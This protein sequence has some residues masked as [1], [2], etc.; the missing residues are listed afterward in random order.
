MRCLPPSE[1]QVHSETIQP[2]GIYSKDSVRQTYLYDAH[3]TLF[4]IFRHDGKLYNR[5]DETE[6]IKYTQS[7]L[8]NL[9]HW[10][11]ALMNEFSWEDKDPPSTNMDVARIRGAY[12]DTKYRAL[13]PCAMLTMDEFRQSTVRREDAI[14]ATISRHALDCIEA[15]IQYL[16]S[17]D[18][19]GAAPESSY[20][21]GDTNNLKRPVV[22]NL[23]STL[24]AS[25]YIMPLE[26]ISC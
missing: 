16:V 4:E 8:A 14:Q 18:R 15:A 23:L 9:K 21:R 2:V 10:R 13:L 11:S 7:H 12:Y 26:L 3:R 24:H 17:F 6:V 19:V 22:P 20:K 1:M 5:S 25:V